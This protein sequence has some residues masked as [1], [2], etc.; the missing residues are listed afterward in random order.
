MGIMLTAGAWCP[1]GDCTDRHAAH[2][3]CDCCHHAVHPG[4]E[5]VVP[6]TPRF[7]GEPTH[8]GPPFHYLICFAQRVSWVPDSVQGEAGASS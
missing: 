5:H 4:A 6:D 2:Q 7:R 3:R 1:H 8:V